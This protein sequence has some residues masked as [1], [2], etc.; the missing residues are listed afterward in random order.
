MTVS[1]D[2]D[3]PAININAIGTILHSDIDFN[4]HFSLPNGVTTSFPFTITENASTCTI[5]SPASYTT[6]LTYSVGQP[7]ASYLIPFTSSCAMT[8]VTTVTP[9]VTDQDTSFFTFTPDGTTGNNADA[10]Y[11]WSTS[12]PSH[13]GTYTISVQAVATCVLSPALTYTVTVDCE[14]LTVVVPSVST[15]A[16][17]L[18]D[19]SALVADYSAISVTPVGCSYTLS[20]SVV[21][22]TAS[23]ASPIDT[24]TSFTFDQALVTLTIATPSFD[25]AINTNQATVTPFQY[26]VEVWAVTQG[27]LDIKS[28]TTEFIQ[29][30]AE[31]TDPCYSAVIDLTNTVVPVTS[32]LTYK[33][34]SGAIAETVIFDYRNVVEGT[35]FACAA[36]VYDLVLADGSAID[37]TVFSFDALT[38]VLTVDTTDV[39]KIASYSM[40]LTAKY[41]ETYYIAA[42][43][44]FTFDLVPCQVSSLALASA[45]LPDIDYILGES[46][47]S[48]TIDSFDSGATTCP[49]LSYSYT[50]DAGAVSLVTFNSVTREFTFVHTLTDASELALSSSSSPYYQ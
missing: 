31:I 13:M 7:S 28:V 44:A 22:V 43:E 23:P 37:A 10:G 30:T 19:S 38:G 48:T 24:S 46:E 34:Y 17:T 3:T 12:D 32:L 4:L 15:L 20:H 35:T 45:P 49:D 2:M 27:G 41:D 39:A 36:I 26:T 40:K 50:V 5:T 42:E 16:Y 18:G 1:I 6:A 25:L 11:S 29:V 9:G 14:A 33:V 8:Y 21:E 47:V